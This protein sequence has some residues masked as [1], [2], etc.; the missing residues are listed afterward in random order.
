MEK[1]FSVQDQ[2]SDTVA[3]YVSREMGKGKD[4]RRSMRRIMA[5]WLF[6]A[7]NHAPPADTSEIVAYLMQPAKGKENRMGPYRRKRSKVVHEMQNTLALLIV[8]S[9]KYPKRDASNLSSIEANKMAKKWVNSRKFS[10]GFLKAGFFPPIRE[11]REPN[12]EKGP[13]YK[14]APGAL[15]PFKLTPNEITLAATNFA[16]F[17]A[18]KYPNAFEQGMPAVIQRLTGFLQKDMID[19]MK[20]ANLDAKAL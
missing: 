8:R 18:E 10:A 15:I 5:D 12:K 17:I 9:G 3:R 14:N 16:T 4:P 1:T 13:R 7:M 20:A 6:Q 2:F 19:E 11:L